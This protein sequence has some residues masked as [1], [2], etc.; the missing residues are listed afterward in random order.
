MIDIEHFSTQLQI[1]RRIIS[2]RHST[3]VH[4]LDIRLRSGNFQQ[5]HWAISGP[6]LSYDQALIMVGVVCAV[7][8]KSMDHMEEAIRRHMDKRHK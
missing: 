3:W 1:P 8:Q 2:F 7:V 5:R 4:V 6:F